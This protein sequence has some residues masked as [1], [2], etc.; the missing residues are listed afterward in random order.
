MRKSILLSDRAPCSPSKEKIIQVLLRH[1]KNEHPP[2][3]FNWMGEPGRNFP[4]I[5]GDCLRDSEVSVIETE[6]PVYDR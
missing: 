1:I 3:N 2:C 6:D 4:E 5:V